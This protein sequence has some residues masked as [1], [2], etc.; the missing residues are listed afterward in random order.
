MKLKNI[1]TD[2]ETH[3]VE[4]VSLSVEA[5][6]AK[7]LIDTLEEGDYA[8]ALTMESVE[9]S[10]SKKILKVD[11]YDSMCSEIVEFDI[12]RWFKSLEGLVGQYF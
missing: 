4:S 6:I 11:F 5:N 10:E 3:F 2:F 12:Q 8:C 9:Y 7:F 1:T